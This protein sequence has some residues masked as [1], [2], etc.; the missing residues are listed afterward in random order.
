[1]Q[2]FSRR[3][4][5]SM[6]KSIRFNAAFQKYNFEDGLNFQSLLNE[7]EQMVLYFIFKIM[8]NARQFAQT[9]LMPR[10]IKDF[11]GNTE[12]K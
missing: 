2:T 11:R 9:N 12:D 5:Q 4:A 6:T 10:V 1:M 7:E 3:L 8:E